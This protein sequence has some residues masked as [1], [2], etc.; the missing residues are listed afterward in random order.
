MPSVS[1]CWINR[2]RSLSLGVFRNFC[3]RCARVLLGFTSYLL[4]S[5]PREQQLDSTETARPSVIIG[6]LRLGCGEHI[7]G[8]STDCKPGPPS[9]RDG[10]AE[11]ISSDKGDRF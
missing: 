9:Y 4:A 7:P 3:S 2:R 6:G 10:E 8:P 11:E 5:I 1:S